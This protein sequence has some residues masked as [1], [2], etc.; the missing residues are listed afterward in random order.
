MRMNKNNSLHAV[1]KV[2]RPVNVPTWNFI[3]FQYGRNSQ[4]MMFNTSVN[5]CNFWANMKRLRVV[6]QLAEYI[7]KRPNSGNLSLTCPLG[8]GTYTLENI[9]VPQ[10]LSAFK[11]FYRPNTTYGLFGNVYDQM[12]KKKYALKCSYEINATIYKLC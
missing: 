6:A 8:V 1:T 3:L 11:L 4:N 5:V 12:S 9:H 2:L 7:L 10:E